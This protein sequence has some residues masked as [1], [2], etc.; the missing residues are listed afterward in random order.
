M[1]FIKVNPTLFK[2]AQSAIEA[3][4]MIHCRIFYKLFILVL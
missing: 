3:I 1:S 2:E 4:V